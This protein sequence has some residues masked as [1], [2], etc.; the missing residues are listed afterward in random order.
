MDLSAYLVIADTGVYV[1]IQVETK[2]RK[3]ALPFLRLGRIDP[4]SRRCVIR[5]KDAEKLGQI[6][7][8]WYLLFKRNW[9]QG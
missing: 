1:A 2:A 6:L 5:R 4:A 8:Q 3:D 9:C 7:S